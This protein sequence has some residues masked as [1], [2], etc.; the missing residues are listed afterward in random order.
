MVVKTPRKKKYKKDV[1]E[2]DGERITT[3]KLN[4][5]RKLR[6]KTRNFLRFVDDLAE[7]NN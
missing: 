4:D 2:L 5:P 1:G 6:R 3:K 7:G